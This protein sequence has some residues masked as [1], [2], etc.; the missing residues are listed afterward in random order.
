MIHLYRGIII[1]VAFVTASVSLYSQ[2]KGKVID[3]STNEPVSGATILCT[4]AGASCGTFSNAA[5]D[6]ELKC[7]GCR[8]ISVSY[9]GYTMVILKEQKDYHSVR[10]SR[11][12]STLDEIV[13]SAN[14]GEAARRSQAPVAISIISQKVIQDNKPVTPDQLLN[15]ISGVNMVSLGNEQHQMSIRQPITTRS[16]FLYLEDGIPIRTTGLFNHNALLEMNMAAVK[17]IEVIKGPSSALY[18][19]EAIGG[20]VNFITAVPTVV[21]VLKLSAQGNNI[22]YKRMDVNSSFIKGKWGFLL[23]GY[24]ANRRNGYLEYSDYDKGTFTG[25]IDYHFSGHTTLTNGFTWINYNSDMGAGIDSIMFAS[26]S[27]KNPQT[28]TYRKVNAFRYHSTLK[29]VWKDHSK[30]SLTILYRNNGI[31]QNPAYRVKDD[32]RRQQSG[33]YGGR[34]DVAHGEI[35]ES[36]FNSYAVVAQHKQNLLMNKACLVAGASLDLSPSTYHAQYISIKKDTAANKY[37]GYTNTDSVL[38]NYSTRLNNYAV[39]ANFEYSPAT[40]LRIVASLRY[41]VFRYR[42]NN[43]L[44]PSAFSGS[45]DTMNKFNRVSPK[46]GLTYN[47]TRR[48]GIYAN[49]SE[50]FVPPQVTELY[51]GVKVPQIKPSVFTNYEFG[52]WIE[53]LRNKLSADASIYHLDGKNEIITVKLDDGSFANRNAGRTTHRGVEFGLNASP[54][55]DITFRFSGAYSKHIFVDYLERGLKFDGNEMN[56]APHWIYNAEVWYK[57]SYLK[58]LRVGTEFQHVGKY[59]ADPQNT[60]SYAGY[61]V[62]NLRIGYAAKSWEVWMNVLNATDSYYSYITTKSSFGYS[63]QLAEPK[64]FNVGISYDLGQLIK[65]EK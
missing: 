6:F 5:G 7:H 54:V 37:S 9:V 65:K 18:G 16:L 47:F 31:E 57:P 35:N 4:D 56:S 12:L 14:R 22:G 61:D 39:F 63:Y 48:L 32:Y 50:G 24:Y 55:R 36:T 27:F 21:P 1:A 3:D 41:D 58:G 62:L 20:A 34:K 26:K 28:F 29:H 13:F 64:N 44:T 45:S 15:K 19:S 60:S 51:T 53:L 42:F 23:S 46:V 40:K 33:I 11:S 30:T 10:L 59:Y 49:Y 52:G 38:T 25:K 2:V 8:N 17:S 43:F